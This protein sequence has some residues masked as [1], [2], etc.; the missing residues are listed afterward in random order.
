[1][2]ANGEC[3]CLWGAD[4]LRGGTY[5]YIYIYIYMSSP[6]L[7]LTRQFIAICW[8]VRIVDCLIVI[9]TLVLFVVLDLVIIFRC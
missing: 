2:T 5:I 3:D 9:W 1:M 7:S 6:N 4:C 8:A